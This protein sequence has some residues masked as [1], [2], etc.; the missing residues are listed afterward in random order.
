MGGAWATSEHRDPPNQRSTLVELAVAQ[1]TPPNQGK[2]QRQAQIYTIPIQ[3][4]QLNRTVQLLYDNS[5]AATCCS[6]PGGMRMYNKYAILS[7]Q[8]KAFIV[9]S[10]SPTIAAVVAAPTLKLW[11]A[12]PLSSYPNFSSACLTHLTKTGFVKGRPSW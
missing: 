9:E 7:H 5:F 10:W 6:Y 1:V 11:P 4:I 3:E 2:C 8:P 12:K